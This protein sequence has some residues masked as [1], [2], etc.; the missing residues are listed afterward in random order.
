[1]S[2]KSSWPDPSPSGATQ[3]YAADRPVAMARRTLL[4]LCGAS[5]LVDLLVAAWILLGPHGM[6][7]GT[8]WLVAGLVVVAG[9]V[10]VLVF[11]RTA[12]A[13]DA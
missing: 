10:G 2:A 9:A 5:L 11:S 13:P 8:R 6:A 12:R 4:L 3:P 7:Q 1:M